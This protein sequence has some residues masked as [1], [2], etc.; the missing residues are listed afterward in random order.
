M[1]GC[2]SL[3]HQPDMDRCR[4]AREVIWAEVNKQG[5]A[6]A[7][8]KRAGIHFTHLYLWRKRQRC[9]SESVAGRLRAVLPRVKDATWGAALAPVEPEAEVK[10]EA[11]DESEPP[12]VWT[13]WEGEG[14]EPWVAADGGEA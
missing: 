2:L 10:V 13:N 7:V 12:V 1:T 5:G 14:V 8:A 6:I 4:Q 11:S 3:C 9:F